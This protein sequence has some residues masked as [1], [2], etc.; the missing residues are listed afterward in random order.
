MPAIPFRQIPIA[1]FLRAALLVLLFALPSALAAQALLTVAPQQ[2]VWR[3]G[4]NAAWA[5][6][7]L[8]E[9]AWQPY[10]N[11]NLNPSQPRTWVRCHA[12][13][14]S[15]NHVHQPALQVTLYAAYQVFAD[16][17]LIGSAGN[18]Q[19]GTFTMNAVRDWPLAAGAAPSSTL[20]LRITYRIASSVP[21]GTLP[22]LQILA[23]DEPLLRDRRDALAF[24]Q[25]RIRFVPSVCFSITG[26]LGLVL[27]GLWL[28]DRSR[29]EL[30]LL[31]LACLSLTPIYLDYF[32]AG[33]LLAY[34]AAAYFVV[35]SIFATVSNVS[36]YS[37]LL[38]ACRQ[39]RTFAFLDSDRLGNC[40]VLRDPRDPA[41][42]R[43][44]VALARCAPFRSD[45]KRRRARCNL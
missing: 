44:A 32:G 25:I 19:N 15:L 40:G 2:C 18:L 45:R 1:G 27:L 10:T 7:N 17:H 8:D 38:C 21:V 24:N 14:S 16:G 31:S 13:L 22:P 12:D 26:I 20:A 39:A 34:S 4:D 43:A 5:A 29:H 41:S 37:L 28:N 11:W 9:S 3:A 6:P 42:S 35:W 23:G 33:A 30:L 36:R